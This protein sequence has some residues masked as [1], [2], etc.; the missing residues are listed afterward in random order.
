MW[1]G[2]SSSRGVTSG[3]QLLFVIAS[4][5]TMVAKI[6]LS[7][8]PRAPSAWGAHCVRIDSF[9]VCFL[10]LAGSSM[11]AEP[12]QSIFIVPKTT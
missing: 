6:L 8:C 9:Y 1:M 5:L 10:L 2:T 4:D 12:H 11:M 3:F 7:L